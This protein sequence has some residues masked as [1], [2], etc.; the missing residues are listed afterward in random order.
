M[1]ETVGKV[2]VSAAV[3]GGGYLV[4]RW[5]LDRR[6]L[7]DPARCP[8]ARNECPPVSGKSPNPDGGTPIPGRASSLDY[9]WCHK[10]TRGQSAGSIALEVTGDASRYRELLGANTHKPTATS[11]T[12]EVNF[13]SLCVGE[14]LSFPA[15]WNPWIDQT[16]APR[17]QKTAFP[18]YDVIGSYPV[19]TGTGSTSRGF[20]PTRGVFGL[21]KGWSRAA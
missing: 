21:R 16:G 19:V 14:R 15:S 10:V 12:G 18:P 1:I 4:V 9:P 17:R 3:L 20:L 6:A 2:L 8:S 5:A 13:T 7:G 11:S